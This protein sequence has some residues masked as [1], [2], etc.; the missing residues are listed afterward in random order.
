MQVRHIGIITSQKFAQA[1]IN[2]DHAK[3]IGTALTNEGFAVAYYDVAKPKDI[4]RILADKKSKKL[5]LIFNNAAGRRGGDGT[6]EG[7]LDILDIPYIG[8][9]VLATAVAFDKKSTKTMVAEQGVP[10]IRG[11]NFSREEFELKRQWVVDQIEQYLHYPVVIKA[12][13]GSDSIGVSLVRKQEQVEAA[14][15]RAFKEDGHVLVE[16]FIKRKAEITCMVLG[17]G[18]RAYAL[19]PVERVYEGDILYPWNELDRTYRIPTHIDQKILDQIEAYSIVAHN[20]INCSDYSRSDFLVNKTG[21][22]FFLELNAHAGLGKVG[23]TVYTAE[24]T[25]GWNH[26][27]MIKAIVDIAIE[28]INNR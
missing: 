2:A 20:A 8:S 16:D 11:F 5:D 13:Q 3:D 10:I 22:I 23:P 24:A 4:D 18:E 7:L 15:K 12:S 27:Q 17:N 19:K 14:L 6:V 25:H 26:Q 1:D 28:R 21:E 9:D